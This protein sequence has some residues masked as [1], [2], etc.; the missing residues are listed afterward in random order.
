MI[1]KKRHAHYPSWHADI[2]IANYSGSGKYRSGENYGVPWNE[3]PEAGGEGAA[4]L[5]R[6]LQQQRACAAARGCGHGARGRRVG[7]V[8]HGPYLDP[9]PPQRLDVLLGAD[10]LRMDAA[11]GLR[12]SIDVG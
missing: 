6:E 1:N 5:V 4:G 8:A 3:L 2:V 10:D 11:R 12:V 9:G 7:V